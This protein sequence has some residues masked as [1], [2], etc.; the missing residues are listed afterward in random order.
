MPEIEKIK[1]SVL[2][3]GEGLSP[4]LLTEKEA[5]SREKTKINKTSATKNASS[6]KETIK[7]KPATVRKQATNL[8]GLK[9]NRQ[10]KILADLALGK[11]V[12]H[13]VAV[14]RRLDNAYVL[15]E[16]HD[17]LVDKLF[18]ELQK[19]GKIKEI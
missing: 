7:I 10:V 11:G 4:E 1:K 3:K 9:R 8:Y 2:E 19:R 17:T 15:D 14:A 16:F 13:A 12:H 6:F 5:S 18:E